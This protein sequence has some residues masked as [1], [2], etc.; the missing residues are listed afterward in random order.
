MPWRSYRVCM[1]AER[2]PRI[3]PS[4]VLTAVGVVVGLMVL[5]WVVGAIFS[6]LRLVFV[7]GVA[8]AVIWAV[9]ASRSGR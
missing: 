5:W 2:P 8:V 6:L 7:V 4:L 9:L 1:D 3:L